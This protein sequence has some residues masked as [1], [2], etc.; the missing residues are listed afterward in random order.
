[1]KILGLAPEGVFSGFETSFFESLIKQGVVVS[2]NSVD[3]PWF[4]WWATLCAFHPDKRKWAVR[5]DLGYYQSISAYE[6]KSKKAAKIVAE[7]ETGHDLIYQVGALWNPLLYHTAKIPFVLQVDYTTV[8]SRKRNAEW[9]VKNE[10]TYRYLIQKEIELFNAASIVLTTTENA[11]Q[12]IL[13]DYGIDPNHV[14]CVGA[15]VSAPY[16]VLD[17]DRKPNYASKN[18]LFVGKGFVGKGLDTLLEALPLVRKTIP[19][20]RLTVVGPTQ[21]I[22]GDGIDYLGRIA[23]RNRVKELYYDHAV[24]AILSR[25]EPLGQVFLEAMSCQ[26]P[27]IGTTIDAMPEMIAHGVSGF[28]IE[29]GD[30]KQLAEHLTFLLNHPDEAEKMGHAGFERIQST[31]NWPAVGN[32]ILSEIEKVISR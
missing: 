18:I 12:S 24:F 21:H 19:D 11:R 5:R 15:G 8:L 14:V 23:D 32:R 27:C 28:I 22:E 30:S 20:A 9:N 1:M 25:F 7:K 17:P 16:N 2:H 4:K 13:N 10:K 26:L 29:P 3:I 31:F 6:L